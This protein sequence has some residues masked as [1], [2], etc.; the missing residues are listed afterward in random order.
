[1]MN[2][3]AGALAVV[4]LIGAYAIVFGGL[5]LALGFRLRGLERA[6]HRMTPR[7]V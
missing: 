6:A 7:T 5:L 3:R 4:W 2:P 1:L